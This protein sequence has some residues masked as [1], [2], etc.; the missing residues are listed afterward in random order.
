MNIKKLIILF[1]ILLVT[2]VIL[3]KA[4]ISQFAGFAQHPSWSE[5]KSAFLILFQDDLIFY[6]N[7]ATPWTDKLFDFIKNK[8][9]GTL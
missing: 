6:K 2:P 8:I 5:F 1:L 9:K 7:L 3:G 4:S